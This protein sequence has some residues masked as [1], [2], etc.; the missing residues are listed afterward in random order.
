MVDKLAPDRGYGHEVRVWEV[1]VLVYGERDLARA[2]QG[3]VAATARQAHPVTVLCGQKPQ[4]TCVGLA[5]VRV[6]HVVAVTREGAV[7]ARLAG[8]VHLQRAVVAQ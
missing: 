2:G 3:V 4:V 8:E 1:L 5:P 6:L 7:F